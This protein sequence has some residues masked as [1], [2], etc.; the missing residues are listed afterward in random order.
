MRV[1]FRFTKIGKVRW[2]SHRDM[3]RMWERAFRR[4]S[5]PLAY[6]QG[7]S[8]RPRVSFGLALPTGAES[9]AEYL[10]V[11]LDPKVTELD[12]HLP[13]RLTPALPIGLDVTAMGSLEERVDSL[14][15]SVTSC[16]WVVDTAGAG[17]EELTVLVE[18][19]LAAES[20]V[21]PRERKGR[22]ADEDVRP[23]ILSC[24]VDGSRIISELAAHPRTLRPSE[25]L[26]ALGPDLEAADVR[27]THQWIERDGARREPLPLDATGAPH[28]PELLLAG[29]QGVRAL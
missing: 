18:R 4:V 2:T 3:A 15:E 21:I 7:F 13:A 19:A 5:L 6:T 23:G 1:R 17:S 9:D 11:E 22:T 25:L 16:T 14:Q 12:Q 29:G 8:P 24:S 26:R 20:L 10:D 28:A 27:R